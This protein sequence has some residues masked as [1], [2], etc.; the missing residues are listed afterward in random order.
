MDK[1]ISELTT[2]TVIDSADVSVLVHNNADQQYTF[3]TLLSFLSTNL[4]LGSKIS[5]GTTLPQNTTG[6][7]GDVFVNTTSASFAQKISGVWA[8]VYTLP[9]L[10]NVTDGT[11]LYG[12]GTPSNG[13][14]S[15]N[16]TYI[17][18]GTGTFY[19]K[20]AG[21]WSS[22]FTMLNGPAGVRG[23][24]GDKG[25]TGLNGKT[26]LSGTGNPSNTTDGVNGDYYINKS[27]YTLF[28]PK[29]SGAW[30]AGVDLIGPQGEKGEMGEPGVPLS[31]LMD[32]F[33]AKTDAIAIS[34]ITN[35]EDT[36]D[37]KA[38]ITALAA[39]IGGAPNDGNTLNKLY[40]II[41]GLQ[42][43]INGDDINL[44]TIKELADAIKSDE[45]LL[46]LLSIN[47]LNVS[48]VYNA[49][50]CAIAGK[51]LDARQG[52]AL[53]D[54]V[55]ALSTKVM[56]GGGTTGQVLAKNSN[57]NFDAH[58]IDAPTGAGET[59]PVLPII[60]GL[61][62][63][64]D[65]GDLSTMSI[66]DS[67]V[68]SIT[69]KVGNVV[70]SQA[71]P[72]AQPKLVQGR[73]FPSAKFEASQSLS[74]ALLNMSSEMTMII[75][76]K[77]PR[78]NFNGGYTTGIFQ[79]GTPG[80]NGYG[81]VDYIGSLRFGGYQAPGGFA[82]NATGIEALQLLAAPTSH[83]IMGGLSLLPTDETNVAIDTAFKYIGATGADGK[84]SVSVNGYSIPTGG[85]CIGKGFNQE[86]F[87]GE[88][89]RILCYNR[90][91]NS[92]ETMALAN[93]LTAYYKE[94]MPVYFTAIGDSIST[95]YPNMAAAKISER[96][97]ITN[98]NTALSGQPVSGALD[99]LNTDV[100]SKVNPRALNII[101]V[102]IG[103]NFGV[104]SAATTYAGIVR[105]CERCREGGYKVVIHT[106]INDVSPAY[107]TVINSINSWIR[108]FWRFY[109]DA[110]CDSQAIPEL[111]DP[112]DTTYYLDG[113]HPTV[114]G[115]QKIADLLVTKVEK[116]IM[117]YHP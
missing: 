79:Q 104:D 115:E 59:T 22:V 2:A 5:F 55:S 108:T 114:A 41:Q 53:N 3:A 73:Y 24:K 10:G 78:L 103:H 7:N 40:T 107:Q 109:A 1:K 113:T 17:N 9:D 67:K 46:T 81:M 110:L 63:D 74:G 92:G 80:V 86:R 36:L 112:T 52:K 61:V 72:N 14:G 4:P 33:R 94:Q 102:M 13:I 35:L 45:S 47:K 8:I 30:G 88:I 54:L 84:V 27:T 105:I 43:F 87:T 68:A 111:T 95:I 91:L 82:E 34:E 39:V 70:S 90:K 38:D 48:D 16:D 60:S 69:D 56:P 65:F 15:N 18:T 42:A 66:S 93:Y 6:K 26:I 96:Y 31:S 98:Y 75:F 99:S 97:L 85:H 11:V 32:L 83:F 62:H 19:K 106:L 71:D 20:T 76:Y 25:D 101:S 37:N 44:D 89:Q 23:E 116:M 49:L 12:L 51:A 50:D 117:E 58:W 64:F 28:G 77:R 57:T 29:T 21:T 100:I